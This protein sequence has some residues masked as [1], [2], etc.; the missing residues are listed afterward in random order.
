[1]VKS[2]RTESRSIRPFANLS[3]VNELFES[4]RIVVNSEEF[5]PGAVVLSEMD[6]FDAKYRIKLNFDVKTLKKL[7]EEADIPFVDTALICISKSRMLKTMHIQVIEPLRNLDNQSEILLDTDSHPLVYRDRTGFKLILAVV[8]VRNLPKKPL[9]PHITGTWL[10]QA[11]FSVAPETLD[12]QFSPTRLTDAIRV[13]EDLPKQSLS[14]IKIKN[15]DSEML[16]EEDFEKITTT[17]LDEEALALIQVNEND[18][19]SDFMMRNLV[20]ETLFQL[21]LEIEKSLSRRHQRLDY[22][23]I[24]EGSAARNLVTSISSELDI[25][26]TK[27]L[28][29]LNERPA[30]VSSLLESLLAMRKNASSGLRSGDSA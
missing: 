4:V 10:G 14:F 11:K 24:P 6:F 25:H 9:R 18:P 22:Q 12:F 23:D 27:L 30:F 5:E 7:I 29:E 2:L 1:M 13:A 8:L 15:D 17:Y 20:K 21:L 26:P 19:L 16:F 28:E 3:Q